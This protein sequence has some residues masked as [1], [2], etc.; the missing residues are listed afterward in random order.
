MGESRNSLRSKKSAELCVIRIIRSQLVECIAQDAR[1]FGPP[2]Q[3]DLCVIVD[4]GKHRFLLPLSATPTAQ[5]RGPAPPLADSVPGVRA[6]VEPGVK[7][8]EALL[9]HRS[10]IHVDPLLVMPPGRLRAFERNCSPW[11]ASEPSP[12]S[13]TRFS[14]A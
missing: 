2:R 14:N 7:I 5:G 12:T 11:P 1:S 4:A 13:R 9:A 6:I 10:D 3:P 8:V